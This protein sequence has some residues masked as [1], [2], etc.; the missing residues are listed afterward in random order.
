MS[1]MDRLSQC[2][3]GTVSRKRHHESTS[4]SQHVKLT[5]LSTLATVMRT[6]ARIRSMSRP[7]PQRSR[8]DVSVPFSS[9]GHTIAGNGP[10]PEVVPNNDRTLV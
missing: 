10:K 9:H 1:V 5:T 8:Y 2:A 3:H 4:S 7:V 6:R